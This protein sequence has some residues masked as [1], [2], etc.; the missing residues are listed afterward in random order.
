[1]GIVAYVTGKRGWK[2][3]WGM[4]CGGGLILVGVVIG[5]ALG[6]SAAG[7]KLVDPDDG[8][9]QVRTPSAR[10][11]ASAWRPNSGEATIPWRR[12]RGSKTCKVS[13]M[14]PG[15]GAK[16]STRSPR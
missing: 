10:S 14:R 11:N 4:I 15:R 3:S 2:M 13:R 6:F 5:L 9:G 8:L 12:G 1:M 7:I 16:T